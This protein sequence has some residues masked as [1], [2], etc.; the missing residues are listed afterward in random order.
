MSGPQSLSAAPLSPAPATVAPPQPQAPVRPLINLFGNPYLVLQPIVSLARGEVAAVEALARFPRNADTESVFRAARSTDLGVQ[1]E[2][3]CLQTALALRADLPS[4]TLLTINLSP[5]ALRQ[6]TRSDHLTD[7][8]TGIIV[9]ITEQDDADT[10][11]LLPV[12]HE[13]RA[14][15]AALAIDDVTTGYA[16]LLR[17]A[18][19]RP[20]YVKIDRR[21][22]SGVG[23]SVA[24]SAVLEALVTL[25]HRLGA[26]VIAEGVEHLADLEALAA[27]DVDYVQ[28]YAI[29][30]PSPLPRA[31]DAEVA[32][33]CRAS[34]VRVLNGTATAAH[35]AARTRDVYAVTA[36]LAAADA[37]NDIGRALEA[38][39]RDLGIDVISVSVVTSG[40]HLREIA[41]TTGR[42][43]PTHYDIALYPTTADVLAARIS[44]EVQSADAQH[45]PAERRWMEREGYAS[46][47]IVPVA[48]GDGAI[49]VMEFAHRT[50]RQWNA[51]DVA[52][53]QG[54]A[55]H[56]APVLRRLGVGA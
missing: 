48:D 34:R 22:V 31:L 37:R 12:L 8:L 18:H 3:K 52:H 50:T 30:R 35:S 21:V 55:A 46:L 10:E 43:D 33:A 2:E 11:D 38:S 13:L 29:G 17:L 4:P 23:D 19:I 28:G 36:A 26:A 45:D 41:S 25:S 9:E 1:L 6:V 47:L 42:P 56:L 14:R 24:Q 39:A 7:D 16:G 20:D 32:A 51:H 27:H 53:A 5:A 54:L 40:V 49:G 15:G 44:A